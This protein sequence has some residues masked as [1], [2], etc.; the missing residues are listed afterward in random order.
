MITPEQL[1]AEALAMRDRLVAVRRDLHMHPELAFQEVRTAGVI[2][3]RLTELGYE[4]QTGVGKTGVVGVI[5]GEPG[6]EVLLLRF[7]I[8]ALP[9]H[10]RSDAPYRS[11][12]EGVMHACGH[13]A[14]ASI[15]LGVAELLARHRAAWHG[16]AK[17]VF[18]PAEEINQGARAMLADGVNAT[19]PPTKALSMH[20]LSLAPAG[21]VNVSDGPVMGG[22]DKF[23]VVVRGRGTHT[24]EPQNGA[25]PILAATAMIQA[26]STIAGANIAPQDECAIAVGYI[27]GGN[28][29]N[30]VPDTVEFGG[31]LRAYKPEVIARMVERAGEIVEAFARGMNVEATLTTALTQNAPVVNDPALAQLVR[32]QAARVLGAD[33]VQQGYRWMAGEDAWLLYEGKP[34]VYAFIGA[35]NAEKGIDKPHHNPGFD[36][37]EGCLTVGTAVLAAG[38]MKMLSE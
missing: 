19:L 7:D 18:Q 10:E 30:V 26:I 32:E 34:G 36:I 14:H 29:A 28:A 2:A 6:D 24:A 4:V 17:F 27:R 20:V 5:E 21:T 13:D 15:G 33:A 12:N 35:G 22:G 25:S 1:R 38:A 11:R 23:E 31:T 9:I 37:D 8:D 16:T 3:Q